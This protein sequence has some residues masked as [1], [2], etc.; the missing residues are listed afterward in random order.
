MLELN[1][2]IRGQFA[3]VIK[4][5]YGMRLP[6]G[7]R[8]CYGNVNM[9]R[10]KGTGPYVQSYLLQSR[11]IG[12]GFGYCLYIERLNLHIRGIRA[13]LPNNMEYHCPDF[14]HKLPILK[15]HPDFFLV[16]ADKCFGNGGCHFDRRVDGLVA[17]FEIDHF[18]PS[19]P[20]MY[21]RISSLISE[22][23]KSVV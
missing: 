1:K 10:P 8:I 9:L 16:L 2:K 6:E 14:P 20:F 12:F 3:P 15:H 11:E 5:R 18:T 19:F 4:P 17:G 13:N 22:D 21:S 7:H 23:R